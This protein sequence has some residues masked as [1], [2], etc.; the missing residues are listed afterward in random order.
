M[1]S[2]VVKACVCSL[3]IASI[4]MT[5]PASAQQQT[6]TLAEIYRTCGLGGIL[7]GGSENAEL[8]AIISNITSDLGSTAITSGLVTPDSCQG[9][10]AQTA[11]FIMHTYPSL[12]RELAR[13]E[14]EFVNAMLDLRGCDVAVRD[15]MIAD[16]RVSYAGELVGDSEFDRASAMFD[17]LE[18]TVGNH[19]NNCV[20]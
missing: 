16:M 20:I 10:T 9:G 2:S 11:A 14:G 15:S 12:E 13:G 6:K 5:S 19:S 7:F 8:L 4:A 17:S 1:K 18:G 3:G